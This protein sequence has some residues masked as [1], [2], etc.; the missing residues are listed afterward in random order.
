MAKKYVYVYVL[1]LLLLLMASSAFASGKMHAFLFNTMGTVD[2]GAVIIKGYA[3]PLRLVVTIPAK[4]L[5][6]LPVEIALIGL[7]SVPIPVRIAL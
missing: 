5:I 6:M 7:V 2:F 1:V 3:I 4:A